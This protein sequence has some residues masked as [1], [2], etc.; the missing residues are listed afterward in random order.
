MSMLDKTY[1]YMH[2]D[3][4]YSL[5]PEDGDSMYFWHVGNIA[6]IHMVQRPKA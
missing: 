1:I 2:T 6:H 5:W 4:P 3:S